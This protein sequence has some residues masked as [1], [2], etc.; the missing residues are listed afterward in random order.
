MNTT[1]PIVCALVITASF[2]C[3]LVVRTNGASRSGGSTAGSPPEPGV[4]PPPRKGGYSEADLDASY[5]RV[6]SAYQK[7]TWGDLQRDDADTLFTN[8]AKPLRAP[9]FKLASYPAPD[10]EW[11]PGWGQL[12]ALNR[13]DIVYRMLGQAAANRTWTADC[14]ADFAEYAAGWKALDAKIRPRFDSARR[15]ENPYGRI[16]KLRGLLE[17]VIRDGT[18]QDLFIAKQHPSR[19][20]GL[21]FELVEAMYATYDDADAAFRASASLGHVREDVAAMRK[22]GRPLR[23]A[24]F[25][26]DA[27]CGFGQ[28]HGTAKWQKLPS[29][30][31]ARDGATYVRYP[32]AAARMKEI[33]REI[34]KVPRKLPAAAGDKIGELDYD[35]SQSTTK[36]KLWSFNPRF[37]VK[38]VQRQGAG[39]TLELERVHAYTR[40]YDCQTT[41]KVHR[42]HADGRVEYQQRCR[43]GE[44]ERRA[45]ATISF[46]MAPADLDVRPGDKVLAYGVVQDHQH[47]VIVKRADTYKDVTRYRLVGRWLAT[48][49]R[50]DKSVARW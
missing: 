32:V 23:D 35:T 49:E 19:V 12:A 46:A 16:A 13:E 10:P 29:S 28:E 25:E 39:V 50:N 2:G 42:I 6:V 47:S 37:I 43:A 17:E 41:N 34:A 24:A 22:Y 11:L 33:E 31:S 4:R 30:T 7:M 1:R 15:D 26:R 44:E 8:R 20:A 9:F 3:N 48:V 18:K 5:Q 27:Y 36:G 21:Y 14:H 45:T 38:K 40:S